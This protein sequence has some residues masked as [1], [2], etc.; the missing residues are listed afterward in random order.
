MLTAAFPSSNVF[1]PMKKLSLQ[2]IGYSD[3]PDIVQLHFQCDR[4][5]EKNIV[6]FISHISEKMNDKVVIQLKPVIQIGKRERP[7]STILVRK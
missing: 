7:I 1:M 3:A 5:K 2:T 6:A 4:V